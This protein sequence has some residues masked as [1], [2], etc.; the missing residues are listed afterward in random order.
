MNSNRRLYIG[1]VG[2]MGSG[3]DTVFKLIKKHYNE[4]VR[5]AF[6]DAVKEEVSV[7]TGVSVAQIEA[8]KER[9]R[10]L[11]QAWAT[12]FRRH[13]DPD[14]WVRIGIKKATEVNARTVIFTDVRFLNEAEAIRNLGGILFGISRKNAPSHNHASE[15]ELH[16]IKCHYQIEN[17]G[18]LSELEAVV[19]Q[20]LV[21]ATLGP[22]T[23]DA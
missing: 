12:E 9:F 5:V 22:Q 1:L 23:D 19:V 20:L 13:D 21:R 16:S 14:Y 3:K 11:L 18:T 17:N 8:E 10:T 4:A 15:T 2:G 7:A 6:G